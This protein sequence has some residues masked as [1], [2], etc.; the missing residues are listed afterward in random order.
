MPAKSKHISSAADTIAYYQQRCG[1]ADEHAMADL[2]CDLGHLADKRGLDF[3]DEVRRGV[4]HWYVERET[5]KGVLAEKVQVRI[6]IRQ[7]R[8]S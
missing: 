2:I 5:K 7:M 8:Q 4:H 3:L 1:S 6:S